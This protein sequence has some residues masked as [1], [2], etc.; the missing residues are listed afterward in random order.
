MDDKSLEYLDGKV[1]K[2]R[3]LQNEIAK[4]QSALGIISSAKE[5]V[6]LEIIADYNAVMFLLDIKNENEFSISMQNAILRELTMQ[7]DVLRKEYEKL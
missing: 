2:G 6:R 7:M 4:L 3:F 1:A 5:S